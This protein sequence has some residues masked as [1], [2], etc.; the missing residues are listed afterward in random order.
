MGIDK[1]Q[2]LAASQDELVDRI[3]RL[4]RQVLRMRQHQ[5]VDIGRDRIDIGGERLDRVELLQLL[6]HGHR[7]RRAAAHHRHHVTFERQGADQADHGL[8]WNGQVVDE[9]SQ[10]VFEKALALRLEESDDLLVVGRIGRG[11]PEIDL[12]ALHVE[13]HALQ[14]EGDG[15]VLDIGE[16]QGIVDFEADLA[17]SRCDVLIEQ[18]A[19]PLRI[20]AVGGDLVG[21][22][23]R[24]IEPQRDRLVD[25]GE[26]PPGAARQGVEVL[27]GEVEPPGEEAG[28]DNIHRDQHQCDADERG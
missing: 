23:G 10:I 17:V 5:H 13:R 20:N 11:Q 21:E 18:L 9:L 26:G 16:G 6:H 2:G 1:D 12:L 8:L 15:A 14:P 27:A 19:H 22:P 4:V 3:E 7:L 28:G 24:I 25:R